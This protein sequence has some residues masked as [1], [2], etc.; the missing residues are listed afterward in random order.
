MAIL[1]INICMT[2]FYDYTFDADR[3][4]GVLYFD[5]ELNLRHFG[6]RPGQ[7]LQVCRGPG[8][9]VA[10]IP[11]DPLVAFALGFPSESVDNDSQST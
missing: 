8:D 2:K 6:W 3:N 5:G 4:T 11:V 10:L 1:A 7:Y 9:Q